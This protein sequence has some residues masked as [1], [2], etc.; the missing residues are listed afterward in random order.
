MLTDACFKFA[1]ESLKKCMM[2][3]SKTNVF[4]SPHLIYQNLL[5]VYF[6]TDNETENSLRQILHIPD[7]V[8]KA[9]VQQYYFV[10]GVN[11][12]CYLVSNSF[13]RDWHHHKKRESI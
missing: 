8:S 11:Q 3:E 9:V 10:V 6:G 4:F 5:V 2:M 1:L 13:L 12:F 7:D